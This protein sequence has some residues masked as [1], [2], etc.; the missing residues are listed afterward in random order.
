MTNRLENTFKFILEK[1]V[2]DYDPFVINLV[3]MLCENFSKVIRVCFFLVN[4]VKFAVDVKSFD[5]PF[6]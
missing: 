6:V 5:T 4:E 1:T 3:T 2:S